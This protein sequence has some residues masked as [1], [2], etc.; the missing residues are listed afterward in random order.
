MNICN[1]HMDIYS[2]ITTVVNTL[3]IFVPL[4]VREYINEC[5]KGSALRKN[6]LYI[7]LASEVN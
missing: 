1:T 3:I 4:A 7:K 5:H 2:Y 6:I